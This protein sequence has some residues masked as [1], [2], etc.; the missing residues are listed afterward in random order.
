MMNYTLKSFILLVTVM[1]IFSSCTSNN[2][3]EEDIP[4]P[5][6]SDADQEIQEVG[7]S[8]KFTENYPAPDFKGLGEWI[9]SEPIDSI[10]DLKG[11]VV[12]VNF[13]TYTCINCIRTLPYLNDWHD[14]YAEEGLVI[15]AIHTPEFAYEKKIENLKTAVKE[16]E[17]KYPVVQDNDY[18]TWRNYSNRYWPA[19]YLIDK[20]GNVRYQH[21]GEGNYEEIEESIT[22]LLK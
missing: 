12:L 6:I 21:F 18:M 20:E 11:K 16:R 10:K 19:K 13:W 1:V 2:L 4:S 22:E 7:L 15:V 5:E 17:I 3:Q 9:N 8:D 14:K